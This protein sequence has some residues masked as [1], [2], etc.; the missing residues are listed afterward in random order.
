MKIHVFI[1]TLSVSIIC[2][3]NLFFTKTASAADPDPVK[4]SIVEDIGTQLPTALKLGI[5]NGVIEYINNS[6][7]IKVLLEWEPLAVT[8]SLVTQSTYQDFSVLRLKIGNKDLENNNWISK[9][10]TQDLPKIL[11]AF[12]VDSLDRSTLNAKKVDPALLLL[13]TEAIKPS[14]YLQM[15]QE[16]NVLKALLSSEGV[17][18]F[19]GLKP[20]ASTILSPAFTDEHI[21]WHVDIYSFK[22]GGVNTY[23]R[24]TAKAVVDPVEIKVTDDVIDISQGKIFYTARFKLKNA[25]VITNQIFATEG[26]VDAP[27]KRD[28]VATD[29]K[30]AIT[31]ALT[32]LNGFL[33]IIGGADQLTTAAQGLLGG[34]ENTSIVGGG[35]VAFKNTRVSPFIGVN[36]EIGKFGNSIKGGLLFGIGTGDKTSL[37][38]GPSLQASI[39][40]LAAGATIGAEA[41]SEVNFAGMVAVDLSRL[42]N[43]KKDITTTPISV[44]SQTSTLSNTRDEIFNKYTLINYQSKED[45]RLT[46]ICDRDNNEIPKENKKLRNIISLKAS[47]LKL[48]PIPRGVYEYKNKNNVEKYVTLVE[49]KLVNFTIDFSDSKSEKPTCEVK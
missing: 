20:S 3:V 40:T 38:F 9:I 18:Y 4:D 1:A 44:P 22:K 34:T 48:V 17:K 26:M 41:N 45:V 8:E 21:T 32:P 37:F 29:S 42:T 46:R 14:E 10:D 15:Q 33:S 7:Q 12:N 43:S 16:R 23:Y 30:E 13:K 35:L 49:D 6:R 39:F 19:F 2:S 27:V 36:Q 5:A 24:F 28:R 25:G 11:K 47:D 31:A